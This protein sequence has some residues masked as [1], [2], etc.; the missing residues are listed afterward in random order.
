[1][2]PALAWAE[3]PVDSGSG[4]L[5]G[6]DLGGYRPFDYLVE[7]A[8]AAPDQPPVP[9]EVWLALAAVVPGDGYH[10]GISAERAGR[11]VIAEAVYRHAALAGDSAA[12]TRLGV[13][14][15]A[16]GQPADAED[17]YRQA[18]QA[19]Y[20]PAMRLLAELLT[21]IGTDAEAEQWYRAAAATADPSPCA[22]WPSC[23][24]TS[25]ASSKQKAGSAPPPR[26]A[27]PRP[28][29]ASA[30]SSRTPTA[31]RPYSRSTR[32]T[33]A[34]MGG[35]SSAGLVH[36]ADVRPRPVRAP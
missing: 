27:T 34:V 19:G 33:P 32:D 20:P 2:E 13:R 9:D 12:M 15:V 11:P 10:V 14:L 35:R 17:W 5:L 16:A 23:S 1:V 31:R 25:S 29:T 7:Q 18:A 3:E 8:A 36:P 22:A 26:A 24:G 28:G 4:C 30:C 21:R 6:T